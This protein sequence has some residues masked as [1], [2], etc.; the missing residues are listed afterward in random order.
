MSTVAFHEGRPLAPINSPE[1]ER[2]IVR[3]VTAFCV[4]RG[5]DAPDERSLRIG[6]RNGWLSGWHA[7]FAAASAIE[8]RRA[9]T[10]ETDAVHESAVAATGGETPDPHLTPSKESDN[11]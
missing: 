8:A 3:R 10:A 6:I 7:G 11:A 2:D 9:A 5:G 4:E 1:L